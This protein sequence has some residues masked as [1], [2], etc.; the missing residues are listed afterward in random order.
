[1]TPYLNLSLKS[2][3]LEYEIGKDYV[4][5]RFKHNDKIYRYFGDKIGE[6]KLSEMKRFA[7][8]GSGLGAYINKNR[9]VYAS[10]SV[11]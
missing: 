7:M 9:D 6:F 11:E 10:A 3:I 5:I 1:M 2:G 4:R 8:Q